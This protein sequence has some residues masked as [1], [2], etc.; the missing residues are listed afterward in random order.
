MGIIIH[1]SQGCM[2]LADLIN[3]NPYAVLFN[4]N[5]INI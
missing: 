2:Y 4:P 1:A 3:T 5:N